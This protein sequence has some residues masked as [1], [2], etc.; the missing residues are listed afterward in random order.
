[1]QRSVQVLINPRFWLEIFI[2]REMG[3][4]I[5]QIW[6]VGNTVRRSIMQSPCAVIIVKHTLCNQLVRLCFDVMK[7]HFR[8]IRFRKTTTNKIV[9]IKEKIRQFTI[10]RLSV[11]FVGNSFGQRVD[12]RRYKCV[13]HECF[14]ILFFMTGGD[15]TGLNRFYK[16]SFPLVFIERQC[17]PIE[18]LK[19]KEGTLTTSSSSDH[20]SEWPLYN[21]KT[22]I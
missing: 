7:R 3:S 20:Y 5:N 16:R 12:T 10:I 19:S 8:R 9:S 17:Y 6:Q 14:N 1:M 22:T 4:F 13:Y 11:R 15:K 21:I 18:Q 2:D